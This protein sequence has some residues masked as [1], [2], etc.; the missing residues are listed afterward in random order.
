MKILK[1]AFIVW[2]TCATLIIVL[3]IAHSK[4]ANVT[5]THVFCAYNRLFVEFEENGKSWGTIMLDYGGRPIPCKDTDDV[6][7]ENTI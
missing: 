5:A 3:G 2:S 7:I 1:W 4:S 6:K